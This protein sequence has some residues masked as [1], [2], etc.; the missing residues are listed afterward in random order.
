MN[1]LRLNTALALLILTQIGRADPLDTWTWRNPVPPA[2]SLSAV[3]YG[4]GQFVA[5]GDYG[6]IVSSADAVN[7]V[8]RQSGTG[9]RLSAV[10]YGNGEFVALGLG[11][12]YATGEWEDTILASADGVT[13]VQNYLG[14][15][16]GLSGIVYG[17]GQF[18]VVRDG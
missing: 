10:A 2:V 6:T 5:V 9:Y 16:K 13:W 14:T 18:V 15:E 4:I 7:W 3:A 17:N 8:P 11:F 1:A 12:N